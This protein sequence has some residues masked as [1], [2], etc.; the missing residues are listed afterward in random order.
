MNASNN[1]SK[2]EEKSYVLRQRYELTHLF[3]EICHSKQLQF[4][5]TF[6]Y[7]NILK[8]LLYTFATRNT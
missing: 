8:S 6:G 4:T 2:R 5:E 1:F 3:L 7:K